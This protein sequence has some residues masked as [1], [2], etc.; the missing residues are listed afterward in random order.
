[1]Q[2]R[3]YNWLNIFHN[4]STACNLFYVACLVVRFFFLQGT[5]AYGAMLS[6]WT[7]R[8]INILSP[9]GLSSQ[10]KVFHL[11]AIWILLWVDHPV[12]MLWSFASLNLVLFPVPSL[13]CFNII[14]MSLL[15]LLIYILYVAPPSNVP[16]INQPAVLPAILLAKFWATKAIKET[17]FSWV[18][19]MLWR[20]S[21]IALHIM[22]LGFPTNKVFTLWQKNE[23]LLELKTDDNILDTDIKSSLHMNISM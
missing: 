23:C 5:T 15:S 11:V 19:S 1:M 13:L 14:L 21:K 6:L 3:P 12:V 17:A 22:H 9:A 2:Y 4:K 10:S 7:Q 18:A 20:Q 8:A 16:L